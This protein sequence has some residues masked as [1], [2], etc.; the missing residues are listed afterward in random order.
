MLNHVFQDESQEIHLSWLSRFRRKPFTFVILLLCLVNFTLIAI[1]IGLWIIADVQ[2][3]FVASDFTN[4]Y[5]TFT[6]VR[7]GDGGK[8]YDLGVIG[9]Y[10]RVILNNRTI[11]EGILPIL[12]PPFFA[13]FLSP[14]SI[15]PL[16][17]AYYL[18]TII[19]LGLLIW[20]IYLLW[21]L[22]TEWN[23]KE[24]WIMIITVLSFWPLT[25]TFL[26]GQVSLFLLICILQIYLNIKKN[27]LTTAGF[28]LACLMI[29]PQITLIPAV[30]ILNKRYLRTAISAVIT[31]ITLVIFSSIFLGSTI[32]LQYIKLLPSMSNYFGLYGFY[33]AL[34]YTLRGILSNLLGYTQGNLINIISSIT[35]S[36]VLVIVWYEQRH[37]IPA[38]SSQ[39]NLY[40]AITIT[41]SAFFSVHLYPHDDLILILPGVIFYEYLRQNN[42][43]KKAYSILLLISPI[44]F[45]IAGFT[46]YNLFGIFRPPVLLIM[47]FL[48]WMIYYLHLEHQRKLTASVPTKG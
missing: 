29:K 47:I 2:K 37:G 27:K 24:R 41:L 23:N 7:S 4:L 25:N 10:Q 39:F 1:N 43:P 35:L 34:Q 44:V 9:D 12:Y 20:L 15:I 32:W 5:T 48:A 31:F 14:I 28:F 22:F 6:I 21:H 18:W 46:S 33:P 26:L 11:S 17:S 38:D 36:L 40:F 42:Y 19:Q 3:L 8:L 45:L 16:H 13:L 30:M